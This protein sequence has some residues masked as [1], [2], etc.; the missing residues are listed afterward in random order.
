MFRK[1]N[2]WNFNS[3]NS[4]FKLF[5]LNSNFFFS[6]IKR[7]L[8]LPSIN[9]ERKEDYGLQFEDQWLDVNKPIGY[10]GFSNMV[11]Q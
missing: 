6:K 5:E 10:Y 8:N 4:Y 11:F 2:N 3:S 1:R 9:V 7:L